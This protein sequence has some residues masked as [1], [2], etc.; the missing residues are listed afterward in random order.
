MADFDLN[1]DHSLYGR[2]DWLHVEAISAA[3]GPD[4]AW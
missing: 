1:K 4:A 2:S 3:V